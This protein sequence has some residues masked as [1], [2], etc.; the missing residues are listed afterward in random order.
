M[1][2]EQPYSLFDLV[3][4]FHK[5]IKGSHRSAEIISE[6]I[7]WCFSG[8]GEH[9][10]EPQVT[11]LSLIF[12]RFCSR[13][14]VEPPDLSQFVISFYRFFRCRRSEHGS[15]Q[16]SCITE[17]DIAKPFKPRKRPRDIFP[18]HESGIIGKQLLIFIGMH[19]FKFH[20]LMR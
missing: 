4:T 17:I 19:V 18:Q 5:I 12:S 10:R 11:E 9:E 7:I 20:D 13:F 14:T 8:T 6:D 15:I 1:I 16:N 3:F 2:R